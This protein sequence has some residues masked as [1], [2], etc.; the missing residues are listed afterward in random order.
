[1]IANREYLGLKCLEV[2]GEKEKKCFCVSD[3]ITVRGT[4]GSFLFR[5]IIWPSS[6]P[7]SHT[8]GSFD[9]FVPFSAGREEPD[10]K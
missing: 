8:S 9:F 7:T 2:G 3:I 4:Y 5:I 10:G 1:L 6:L